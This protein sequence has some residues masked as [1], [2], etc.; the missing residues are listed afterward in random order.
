MFLD[1][2]ECQL[3]IDTCH[4]DAIC[5]NTQGSFT[6]KCKNGYYGNGFKCLGKYICLFVVFELSVFL[7]CLFVLSH[8]MFCLF[9][10]FSCFIKELSFSISEPLFLSNLPW[11][12]FCLPACV[13]VKICMPA[14]FVYSLIYT[15][16]HLRS[17]NDIL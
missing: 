7:F 17:F 14:C 16:I 11:L 9:F 15:L 13:C 10:L 8:W 6:C 3:G 4:D 2:E 1:V 5:T 12:S